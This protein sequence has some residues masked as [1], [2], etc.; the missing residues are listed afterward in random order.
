M[1]SRLG[2]Q[3]PEV[4]HLNQVEIS[5]RST[6]APPPKNPSHAVALT[7]RELAAKNKANKTHHYVPCDKTFGRG[8]KGHLDKHLTWKR[9]SPD[10]LRW[11]PSWRLRRPGGPVHGP[12]HAGSHQDSRGGSKLLLLGAFLPFIISFFLVDSRK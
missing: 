8:S 10:T 4:S 2:S 6:P 5:S 9:K 3:D 12:T 7:A 11:R 1:L